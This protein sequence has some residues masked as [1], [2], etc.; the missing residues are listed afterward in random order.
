MERKLLISHK[1]N[2]RICG[3]PIEEWNPFGEVH[4]HPACI[5]DQVSD[6]LMAIVKQSF[7]ETKEKQILRDQ[8]RQ[9]LAYS[10]TLALYH[11]H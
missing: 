10:E 2:C 1:P 4:E 3:K 8:E 9:L 5:A 6:A 7:K 11:R